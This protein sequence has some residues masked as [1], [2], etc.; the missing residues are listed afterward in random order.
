M[1]GRKHFRRFS[2]CLLSN[3][4]FPVITRGQLRN[5]N[6]SVSVINIPG[7]ISGLNQLKTTHKIHV[8]LGIAFCCGESSSAAWQD[9]VGYTRLMATAG[10]EIP[11]APAQGV[12][13]IEASESPGNFGPD[14]TS[15]L[16]T[17]K[18]FVNKSGPSG[19]SGHANHVAGN[20]YGSSSQLP[21][22]MQVD[23]YDAN[24]WIGNSFLKVSSIELPLAENRA[25]QNHSWIGS[26]S[27]A[28]S[29]TE[30][31]RRLD[32]SINADGYVCVVGM[33][34][35]ESTV[36]PGLLGQSYHT[37][38]VGRDD[39][40]HSAGFTVNDVAGR[41]KPDIVAPSAS[42]EN[43]TSW[44]TPMVS[45]A[46]GLLVS[47]LA[48]SPYSLAGADKPR[49]VKSLL[50]ATAFKSTAWSNTS[51]RPLDIRNGSGTLNTYHAYSALRAGRANSSPNS[52]AKSKGW[53]AQS[54]S[55]NS[56]VSYFFNIP[57]TATTGPF[58][59][60][61]NWHRNVTSNVGI[62][63]SFNSTMAN[64]NLRLHT[65]NGF[66]IGPAIVESLSSADN[67][68]LVHQPQLAPGS[69]VLVV[70]NLSSS[71]TPFA[72]AWHSL[73]TVG[74]SATIAEAREID[75]QNGRVTISRVGDLT[76]PLLVPLAVSGTAVAGTDYQPLPDSVLIPAGL[77]STTVQIVPISDAV[78]QG[79]RSVVV[80]AQNDFSYLVSAEPSAVV[81][82]RDKPFDRWRFENFS[83]AERSSP[84]VVGEASD[85][86]GD[87]VSNLL[88]FALN[89]GPKTPNPR[90]LTVQET[91]GF[92]TV[93]ATKNPAATDVQWNAESSGNLV[94]WLPAE[95]L[96]NDGI[97][98][99]ARNPNP[100]SSGNRGFLRVK[101]SRP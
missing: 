37:I 97:Q 1:H 89:L 10:S 62:P 39:A 49:V 26:T 32:F 70:E 4:R 83:L 68:E 33:N 16:F 18:T 12:S 9:D 84:M 27:N 92:L 44:T 93:T 5:Y 22:A 54:V 85:P 25:V 21:G 20:Y 6:T 56:S 71:A 74:T 86:D 76:L 24:S 30:I 38:S 60:A 52:L 58:S 34:N 3:I 7:K 19:I 81:T 41:I 64:L 14:R 11:T 95:I 35:G 17:G 65:A 78:I 87:G 31:G 55:G 36:L 75:G 69:Y 91:A 46:A 57:V 77:T 2:T 73:S 80:T 13:Q 59:A 15:S 48:S 28:A 72:L 101:L 43:A 88:E 82:I 40:Q 61:L 51:S 98:F 67:V 42:P 79:D 23:L 29:D 8:L 99:E 94:D 45:G 53:S 66:L 47:K 100:I 63:R 90:P 96:V 50:L